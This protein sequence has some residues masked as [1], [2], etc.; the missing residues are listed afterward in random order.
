ME[1]LC[2]TMPAYAFS[3]VAVWDS[4]SIGSGTA[5]W[6]ERFPRTKA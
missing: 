4:T 5:K 1:S 2:I 3:I 6:A